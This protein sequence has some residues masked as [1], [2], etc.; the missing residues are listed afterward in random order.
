MASG[1]IA[2]DA[3]PERIAELTAYAAANKLD[4]NQMLQAELEYLAQRA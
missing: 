3:R 4:V 2:G 1:V